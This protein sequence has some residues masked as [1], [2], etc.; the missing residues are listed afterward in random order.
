MVQASVW[1]HT[2][3]CAQVERPLRHDVSPHPCVEDEWIGQ[4]R[5]GQHTSFRYELRHL[6]FDYAMRAP[7]LVVNEK[8]MLP[9]GPPTWTW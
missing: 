6:G 8:S 1:S 7:Y 3:D 9:P 5:V 2:R 4:H